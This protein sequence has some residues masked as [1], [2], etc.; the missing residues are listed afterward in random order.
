MRVIFAKDAL[1]CA[2]S[3]LHRLLIVLSLSVVAQLD[4]KIGEPRSCQP[5]GKSATTT[6][7]VEKPVSVAAPAASTS[8][9]AAPVR[10]QGQ[11]NR[12]GHGPAIYPIEGLSPYQNNWKI[13]VLVTDDSDRREWWLWKVGMCFP[14]ATNAGLLDFVFRT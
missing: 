5:D 10:P 3:R 14:A 13:K 12:A 4:E 7:A 6:P 1:F 2:Y 9:T 8:T 11:Q